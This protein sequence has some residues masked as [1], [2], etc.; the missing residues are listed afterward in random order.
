MTL[1]LRHLPC[2]ESEGGSD[3]SFLNQQAP[4]HITIGA[5]APD[6]GDLRKTLQNDLRLLKAALL[7]ADQVKL[8]GI[9]TAIALDYRQFNDMTPGQFFKH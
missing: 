6:P 5:A 1:C 7:Y 8:C 4:L 9:G 3:L 2:P